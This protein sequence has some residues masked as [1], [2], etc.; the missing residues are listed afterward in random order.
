MKFPS[1][2]ILDVNKSNTSHS[3]QFWIFKRF[4]LLK[5]QTLNIIDTFMTHKKFLFKKENLFLN[6]LMKNQKKFTITFN[7]SNPSIFLTKSNKEFIQNVYKPRL[8]VKNRVLESRSFGKEVY[9][10]LNNLKNKYD[11]KTIK[12]LLKKFNYNFKYGMYKSNLLWS[13]F[14]I[15]F[16]RK[17]RIYTKLKYSRTP[18]YDIVSGGAA[19]LFA[20]FLGFLISEKF[21]FELVDS[22]DFYFFFMY[23]VF[24]FFFCRLFLKVLDA[25]DATWNPFSF[26]WLFFFYKNLT[27]MFVNFTFF[28]R[29]F[30][31]KIILL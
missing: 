31:K 24:L 21:G 28:I 9:D 13:L 23:L 18:Q 2:I 14:D 22:G 10:F 1:H 27:L 5:N 17:E 29:N 19:A 15:N 7:L 11:E 25:N 16:L 30:F 4:F 3:S 20:G 12:I 6:K 8:K 26:K